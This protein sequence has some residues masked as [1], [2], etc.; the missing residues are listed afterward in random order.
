M[1]KKQ[2]I[3]NA[4]VTLTLFFASKET[5]YT[6]KTNGD[7]IAEFSFQIGRAKIGFEVIGKIQVQNGN[8]TERTQ[9]MFTPSDE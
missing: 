7:G 8:L 2:P 9:I 5:V 3:S 1:E 4:N 6:T